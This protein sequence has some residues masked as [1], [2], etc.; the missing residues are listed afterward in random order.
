MLV[1]FFVGS[2]EERTQYGPLELAGH[3]P[4]LVELGFDEEVRN[5]DPVYEPGIS[6]P[7]EIAVMMGVV[8]GLPGA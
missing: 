8:V 6:T 2:D 3:C 7:G 1:A 4:L 5:F